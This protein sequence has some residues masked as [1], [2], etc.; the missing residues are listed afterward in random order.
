MINM[1]HK[2]L[3]IN[4]LFIFIQLLVLIVFSKQGLLGNVL[5]ML[6]GIFTLNLGMVILTVSIPVFSKEVFL[7][8]AEWKR[9]VFE[10][11]ASFSYITK[12][13]FTF[14]PSLENLRLFPEFEVL[15]PESKKVTNLYTNFL[16]G[17]VLV[18]T[19]AFQNTLE[20][21]VNEKNQESIFKEPVDYPDSIQG[22][23][24]LA[25][26]FNEK[27]LTI[28]QK[29]DLD[30]YLNIF[31]LVRIYSTYNYEVIQL[32]DENK[33]AM[34]DTFTHT[35]YKKEFEEFFN[36]IFSVLTKDSKLESYDELT[37]VLEK[38]LI[39]DGN[40]NIEYNI[41]DMFLKLK[42]EAN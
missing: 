19:I 27:I 25:Q 16:E 17:T 26:A 11:L 10:T 42:K 29:E 39:I 20:K 3:K 23:Q 12:L 35:M 7:T 36:T 2:I 38:E 31:E 8:N 40:S 13:E 1:K 9:K 18:D 33:Y 32:L 30:V 21:I 5:S 34:R 41:P 15:V 28:M 22:K 6:G 24:E 37:H 4:G 14:S